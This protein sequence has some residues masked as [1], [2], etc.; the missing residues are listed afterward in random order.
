MCK[1][2]VQ[3]NSNDLVLLSGIFQFKGQDTITLENE[4]FGQNYS[5]LV[6]KFLRSG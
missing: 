6:C 5:G 2:Q 3:L 1:T 4:F